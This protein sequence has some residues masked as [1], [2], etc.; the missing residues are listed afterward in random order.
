MPF[1]GKD[2]KLYDNYYDRQAADTRYNQQQK[3]IE[4]LKQ[5]NKLYEQQIQLSKQTQLSKQQNSTYNKYDDVKSR[6]K[7]FRDPETGMLR[8]VIEQVEEPSHISD[9]ETKEKI[10]KL[11]TNA[12]YILIINIIIWTICFII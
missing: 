1:T 10:K 2:G 6:I 11:W 4:Q 5:Q 8:S 9:P 12:F 7:T 3:I